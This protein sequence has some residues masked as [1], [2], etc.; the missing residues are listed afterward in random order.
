[1]VSDFEALK[2]TLQLIHAHDED[3]DT[4]YGLVLEALSLAHRCG[5]DAGIGLD[6]DGTGEWPVVYIELPDVGQVSWHLPAHKRPWDGHSTHE[7]YQRV[8]RFCV[9]PGPVIY[10]P[11]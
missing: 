7:K 3:Y 11:R 8:A 2:T 6:G 1:M 10:L 9:M 4:R 5:Y